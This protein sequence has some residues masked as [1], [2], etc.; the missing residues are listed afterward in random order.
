M[1]WREREKERG[2][3]MGQRERR[4]CWWEREKVRERE[5]EGEGEGEREISWQEFYR[6]TVPI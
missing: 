4:V 2:V 1:T 3:K 6:E 5:G